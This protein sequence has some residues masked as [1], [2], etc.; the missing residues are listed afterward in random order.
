MR[1]KLA[2]TVTAVLAVAIVA[3]AA[4]RARERPTWTTSS[5]EARAELDRG[6]AAEQKFYWSEARKHYTRALELDPDFAAAKL[7]IFRGSSSK[8]PKHGEM[9]AALDSIDVGRLTPREAF[10]VRYAVDSA[11][12][13][14]TEADARLAKY[15]GEHPKDP[16]A[17]ELAVSKAW[18]D[19]RWSDAEAGCKKLLAV[20]PNWV[21][22]QNKLGY[23]AMSQAHW[24]DAEDRFRTYRYIAPDQANPHD[25]L[26]ELLLLRG[27]YDEAGKELEA[28]LAM[29]PDFCASYFH[30]AQSAIM[31][32]DMSESRVALDRAR[33]Q[34]SCSG[35]ELD[36][37]DCVQRMWE[38]F[39]KRDWPALEKTFDEPCVQ[40]TRVNPWMPHLAA[41]MLGDDARARAIEDTVSKWVRDDRG[42][43][44]VALEDHLAGVRLAAE[45]NP[46]EGA[47][48]LAK[49]DAALAYF[50]LDLGLFK[51]YN[52]L[53]WAHVL[54]A[55]G[56]DAGARKLVGEIAAVNPALAARY[57]DGSIPT[58][59]GKTVA[60][61]R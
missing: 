44:S 3:M 58:P 5:P 55:A 37:R 19:Q 53:Q 28:A 7:M 61:A 12:D 54:E 41:L 4:L 2:I 59:A 27:R 24:A 9:L 23:L 51:L 50:G 8:D 46:T 18:D 21:S 29:K 31:R 60:A 47:Q 33:L 49:A 26:G 48:R 32:Q 42:R 15:L 52:R 20:D 14:R 57:D 16:Y 36:V 43:V 34:P 45:G 17:L 13:R 1:K 39:A 38:L 11:H 25:S 22:A 40:K 56:D 35:R 6:I 10:L 30:L